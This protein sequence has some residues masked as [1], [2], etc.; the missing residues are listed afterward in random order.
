MNSLSLKQTY[1]EDKF[2]FL[3]D[4]NS[5]QNAVSHLV[6]SVYGTMFDRFI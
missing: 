6:L 5:L 3:G 1:R 2:I 4:K